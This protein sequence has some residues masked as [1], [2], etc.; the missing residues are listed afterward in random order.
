MI[1]IGISG[2]GRIGRLAARVAIRRGDMDIVAIN[3][4]DKTP[5]QIAYVFAH[6]SVHGKWE[7]TVEYDETYMT[8]FAESPE[9]IAMRHEEATMLRR[10]LAALSARERAV[11]MDLY[12]RDIPHKHVASNMHISQAMVSYLHMRAL[13]KLKLYITA[14]NTG[15]EHHA[16]ALLKKF[17][18]RAISKKE[19]EQHDKS[20]G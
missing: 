13:E 20:R 1:K 10:A 8:E 2:F 15:D 11:I 12:I 3:A 17:N 5:D 14:V 19:A 4:P 7:G 16:I 18:W 9:D 6:D